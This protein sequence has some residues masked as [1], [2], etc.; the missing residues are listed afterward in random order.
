MVCR[1]DEYVCFNPFPW[2]SSYQLFSR[3]LLRSRV[4]IIA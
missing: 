4:T 3:A 2:S 1:N